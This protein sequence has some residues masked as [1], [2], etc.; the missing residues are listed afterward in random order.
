LRDRS[1]R[2]AQWTGR[3]SPQLRRPPPSDP[4]QA[5]RAA[6]SSTCP[7]RCAGPATG[8]SRGI[9]AQAHRAFQNL[10]AVCGRQG[11]AR[12]MREAHAVPHRPVDV[13]GRQRDHAQ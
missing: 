4:I 5:V 6:A 13:S 11:N 12:S 10:K 2:G 3:S 8:Q 9:E 1:S 7:A